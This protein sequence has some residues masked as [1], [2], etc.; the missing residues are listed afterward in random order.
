MTGRTSPLKQTPDTIPE[1]QFNH[2]G[3]A[4]EPTS[5]ETPVA[6]PTPKKALKKAV[7]KKSKPKV[8]KASPGQSKAAENPIPKFEKIDPEAFETDPLAAAA[9]AEKNTSQFFQD[10]EDLRLDET[11]TMGGTVGREIRTRV[12]VRRPGRK[13]FIRAHPDPRMTVAMALYVDDGEDGDGDAYP[14]TKDMRDTFGDDVKPTLLQVAMTRSGV[15]F[16][17]PLKIPQADGGRGR[18]L[19]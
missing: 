9:A 2:A 5:A 14:V 3:E 6:E 10:L 19:A 1:D 4:V 7:A 11:E 13:E 12:P 15:I 16:L 8:K 17:W 18:S